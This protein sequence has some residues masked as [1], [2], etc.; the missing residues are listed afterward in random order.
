MKHRSVSVWMGLAL[1]CGAFVFVYEIQAANQDDPIR[2]RQ[3]LRIVCRATAWRV[4]E[5]R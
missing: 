3:I 1:L 2:G 5:V 4:R